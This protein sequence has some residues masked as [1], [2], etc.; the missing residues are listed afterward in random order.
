MGKKT[1]VVL[2]CI[3]LDMST[4]WGAAS[5]DEV[6][7]FRWP[8]G[9]SSVDFPRLH[10]AAVQCQW[11]RPIGSLASTL[12]CLTAAPGLPHTR[13]V[14]HCSTQ[15]GAAQRVNIGYPLP[16]VLEHDSTHRGRPAGRAPVGA[17]WGRLWKKCTPRGKDEH[18]NPPWTVRRPCGRG[19]A[20]APWRWGG[21]HHTTWQ[22]CRASFSMMSVARSS[23]MGDMYA[24]Y[25]LSQWG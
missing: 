4:P 15:G 25:T 9:T 16:L 7:R 18:V 2:L 22:V 12:P 17:C 3:A 21:T 11:S 13:R 14:G 10:C 20:G 5:V 8:T 23:I 1:I 6:E 19:V 24:C